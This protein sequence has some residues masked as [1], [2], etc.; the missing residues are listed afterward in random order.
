MRQSADLHV[1]P[2]PQNREGPT[3]PG[4]ERLAQR[5]DWLPELDHRQSLGDHLLGGR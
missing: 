1:R 2:A 4:V 5:I 3:A